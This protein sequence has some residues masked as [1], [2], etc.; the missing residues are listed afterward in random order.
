MTRY[1]AARIRSKDGGGKELD[2]AILF[3]EFSGQTKATEL[4]ARVFAKLRDR[5]G[6]RRVSAV[7][8]DG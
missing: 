4:Q 1:L 5:E 2:K 6:Q 3:A 8:A 7:V